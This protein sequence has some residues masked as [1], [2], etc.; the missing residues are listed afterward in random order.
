[1]E[2]ALKLYAGLAAL[3]MGEIGIVPVAALA[4]L[5]FNLF[6]PP[7]FAAIGAMNAEIKSKKWLFAGV[8][9]QLAVGYTVAFVVFFFGTLITGGSLGS[10]WMPV[11]GW[12]IVGAIAVV[13]SVMIVKKNKEIQSE[14]THKEKTVA[15]V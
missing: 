1:M 3:K 13:L 2:M 11:L 12:A 10:V 5:M 4:F 7:C 8:G 6:T 14:K 15:K 9:L